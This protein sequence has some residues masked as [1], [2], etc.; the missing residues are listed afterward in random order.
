MS[1]TRTSSGT[2]AAPDDRWPAAWVNEFDVA[3]FASSGGQPAA[4]MSFGGGGSTQPEPSQIPDP[5]S[6]QAPQ[7]ESSFAVPRDSQD[8]KQHL[9]VAPAIEAELDRSFTAGS[10][11][12]LAGDGPDKRSTRHPREDRGMV[13]KTYIL[14]LLVNIFI[15]YDSGAVPAVVDVIQAEL[16]LTPSNMGLIGSMQYWGLFVISPFLGFMLKKF[17]QKEVLGVL[18]Y[19]NA[20]TCVL[21]AYA[22]TFA[23]MMTTR[24]A[25][26]ISQA[27]FVI[28]SPCWV[29]AM[30]PEEYKT[31]WMGIL[32]AV[33]PIG[34]VIGYVTAGSMAAS[35]VHWSY[36]LFLQATCIG[37]LATL[38]L[39]VPYRYVDDMHTSPRLKYLRESLKRLKVIDGESDIE[40][41]SEGPARSSSR[42]ME[43]STFAR[44]R[45][46]V[47]NPVYVSV[48]FTLCVLWF[49][50]TGV[51]Y[52]AT[53]F[54][55]KAFHMPKGLVVSMFSIVA[56]T[57]PTI[58]VV[59]GAIVTDKRGGYMGQGRRKA[60]CQALF[61]AVIAT[62]LGL[63]AGLV[64]GGP[65]FAFWI[66]IGLIWGVLA[67]GGAMVPV[68]T[69][70]MVSSVP[71]D[72]KQ[73][74]SGV[75]QGAYN[76]LGYAMGTLV[77]GILIQYLG[78]RWGMRVLLAW[79]IFG[80]VGMSFG[81]YAVEKELQES[82]DVDVGAV[83]EDAIKGVG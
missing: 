77:P 22:E 25:I 78:M 12:R 72:S 37:L 21:F 74:A 55:V 18:L 16:G 14:L 46:L 36:S 4:D 42:E 47:T 64:E 32:Q 61:C 20:G 51:Q 80:V 59:V 73:L 17:S 70:V 2:A 63:A 44:L 71:E 50:V 82:N 19:L 58:G 60:M 75:G 76:L 13:T 26:G 23:Q 69:G 38:Y 30:A 54:F 52:W 48:T 5:R 56:L 39:F 9:G 7:A 45:G 35:G 11:A 10:T 15:N 79:A 29:D 31:L 40:G 28:Y 27:G 33:V 81:L 6:L 83:H 24:L 49:I 8:R 62:L 67:F 66:E 34:V 68:V 3:S 53:E 57:G 41:M 1:A 65:V 43:V